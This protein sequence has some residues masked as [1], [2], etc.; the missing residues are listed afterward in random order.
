MVITS[1]IDITPKNL[2]FFLTLLLYFPVT[3]L[4]WQ[5]RVQHRTEMSHSFESL[6]FLFSFGDE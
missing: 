1:S 5:C 4:I 2:F 6:I 3:T